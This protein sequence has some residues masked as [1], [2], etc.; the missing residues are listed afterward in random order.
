MTQPLVSV[1][2]PNYNYGR[3]IGEAI[4]SVLAQTHPHVEV[5][6]VDDGS[7]DDSEQVVARYPTVRWCPQKNA[8]VS[9][10][11]NR[12]IEQSQGEFVA[13]LDADDRWHPEKL[14]KQLQ[15][16]DD[17]RVGLVHCGF[18]YIDTA[19]TR[20]G[21]R[22]DGAEGDLLRDHALFRKPTVLAGGSTAL[23]RRS[24]F[25]T[26]GGFDLALS[27]S[28]DW[29]MWRR[30]ACTHRIGF[31]REVLMSYRL[32]GT[33]MHRNLK[34]FERDMLTAFDRMFADPAARP[35]WPLKR[36]CYANLYATFAGSYLHNREWRP[37]ARF[38][39]KSLLQRPDR[40]ALQAMGMPI[41]R[42]KNLLNADQSAAYRH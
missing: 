4:E 40:L 3:Y 34:L 39:L 7:K 27:T 25:Q 29:D 21:N 24:C 15:R 13:F 26:A 18:E 20:L 38:G 6:V 2:I 14:A 35:I 33:S 22:L 17:P 19:G 32:H 30:I 9:A 5:L 31:V 8:G 42:L 23:V 36:L 1:V 12:G 16:F 11:R 37:A 41:R 28:A 10:A